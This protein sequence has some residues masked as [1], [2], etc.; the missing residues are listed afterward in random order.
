M[1]MEYLTGLITMVLLLSIIACGNNAGNPAESNSAAAYVHN[2]GELVS[3]WR[4]ALQYLKN[5][6]KRYLENRTIARNTNAGDRE[7]LKGSQK[8]FAVIVTC[9]DSR[10]APEIYFD[11][12][13][14]DIFVIRNA[15]NIAD[16]T[17]LGSIEYAVEHLKAPLVVVVGHSSCGAV[18]GALNG[19]EY[20]EN[21]RTIINAISPAIKN[22]E[23]LDGAIHAN[24]DHVVRRI[25]ENKI[26][27]EMGATVVGAHYNIESGEVSFTAVD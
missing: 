16:T 3:D 14:G 27:E 11:Q 9:S 13:L 2:P 7:V 18:T 5:G 17:A 20:P 26:V 4:V 25:K 22:S 23:N 15:G 1:K 24:I 21:L 6:N 12:K 19:G 8:P 10:V